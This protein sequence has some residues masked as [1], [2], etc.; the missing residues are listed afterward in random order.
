MS[1]KSK[2][3]R[4]APPSDQ[5]VKASYN[6]GYASGRLEA[7]E[8]S[9]DA[10]AALIVKAETLQTNLSEQASVA[11]QENARH[12]LQALHLAF[13]AV[14]GSVN[15]SAGFRDLLAQSKERLSQGAAVRH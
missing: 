6:A 12:T 7:T 15:G 5:L 2:D 4:T 9:M 8:D 1:Q 3:T 13:A 11:M 10:V 14:T